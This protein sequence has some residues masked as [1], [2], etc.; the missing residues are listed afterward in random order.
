MGL[1]NTQK[2]KETKKLDSLGYKHS[3]V[4]HDAF[5]KAPNHVLRAQKPI[6]RRCAN[7]CYHLCCTKYLSAITQSSCPPAQP[8]SASAGLL[9]KQCSASAKERPAYPDTT[10]TT[11]P[12][13]TPL[14]CAPPCAIMKK[15]E[16]LVCWGATHAAQIKVP[17]DLGAV[18]AVSCGREATCAI[19]KADNKLVCFGWRKPYYHVVNPPA[20][21]GPV[22]AVSVTGYHGCAIKM[23]KSVQCWGCSLGR[24]GS[25]SGSKCSPRFNGSHGSCKPATSRAA[26]DR[27]GSRFPSSSCLWP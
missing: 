24:S 7:V 5:G 21:L 8:C 11:T 23:D 14:G 26:R 12:L 10:A 17:E 6:V 15:T 1:P 13:P 18:S 25:I 2:C 20:D 4:R 16:K 19:R 27:A 22:K 3:R 9:P